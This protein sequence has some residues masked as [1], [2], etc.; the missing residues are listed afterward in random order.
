[1]LFGLSINAQE[2]S[3]VTNSNGWYM[4]SGTH[5][6]ND[7]WGLHTLSHVRR[8]N[9]ITDW[10]QSLNRIGLTYRFKNGAQ[11]A[12][13]YD[14]VLTYPYGDLPISEKKK[15]HAIW[16]TITLKQD[17][18]VFKVSHRYRLEQLFTTTLSEIDY[19]F[20]NRFRYMLSTSV[21]I[22]GDFFIAFFDEVF[23]SFGEN[24]TSNNLNQNRIYLGFGKKINNGNIQ[25]GY[26]NQLIKKGPS[27]LFEMDNTLMLGLNYNF[28]FSRHSNKK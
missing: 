26:M 3:V 16:E 23:I 18:G 19:K 11:G 24:V 6:L 21:N 27:A 12:L 14:Y 2:N 10:Q 5:R 22:K 15:T 4:Y 8:N 7:S 17:V 25:I 1:M 28:D 13:G 20:S 9:I